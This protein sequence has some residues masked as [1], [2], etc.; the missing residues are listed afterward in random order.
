MSAREKLK[1]MFDIKRLSPALGA[2]ITGL[3]LSNPLD[4]AVFQRVHR[5]HLDFLVLVFRDKHLTPEQHIAFSRRFGEL[6]GHVFDQ[7]LLPGHPEILQVSNKKM[8]DG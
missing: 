7:F 3:D 1:T 6:S 4:D 8:P 2:E 5:A